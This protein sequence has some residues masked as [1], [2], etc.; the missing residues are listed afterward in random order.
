MWSSSVERVHYVKD[1][2]EGAD[3]LVLLPDLA[4][5]S[6]REHD[7]EFLSWRLARDPADRAAAALL[8][9]QGLRQHHGARGRAL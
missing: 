2:G 4:V 1:L 7:L 3:G 9:I 6:V 8:P 5:G